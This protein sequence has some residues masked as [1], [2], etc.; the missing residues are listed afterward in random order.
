MKMET[1]IRA[2]PKICQSVGKIM[3]NTRKHVYNMS[4]F[5]KVQAYCPIQEL[6]P[7]NL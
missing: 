6:D 2:V 5:Y 4:D 3:V 1:Q 7:I